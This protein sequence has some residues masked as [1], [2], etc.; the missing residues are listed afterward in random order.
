MG[1]SDVLASRL[2]C[3]L[4][5]AAMNKT[6][7]AFLVAGAF[8]TGCSSSSS[9]PADAAV[10]HMADAAIDG[11]VPVESDASPADA[12]P[13]A[14]ADAEPTPPADAN[15]D[16]EPTPVADAQADAEPTPTTDAHPAPDAPLS[17]DAD[18]SAPTP[19]TFTGANATAQY[20]NPAG[21]S[22]FNDACP[23]GQ[24]LI[25]FS[26]MLTQA[27]GYHSQITAQ[28]GAVNRLGAPGAYVLN[29]T[30]GLTL[31]TRGMGGTSAWSSFCPTNTVVSGFGSRSGGLVDQ[32]VLSCT[33]L[34]VDAALG[35]TISFG[36]VTVLAPA[37][38]TGGH[39]NPQADCPTGQVA[40]VARLRGGDG[41][42]AFGLA[43]SVPSIP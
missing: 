14:E 23:A 17:P 10:T 28:C 29:V 39:A 2:S 16:A 35:T 27:G 3:K 6:L 26:G 13:D 38:G 18:T 31:P 1:V 11:S 34:G 40:T 41:V 42:D 12:A 22:A 4:R 20:G 24:A 37:G 9:D 43:C 8:A 30:G 7:A 5:C 15:I 21:G 36:T 33:P 19:V 32:I 25:G